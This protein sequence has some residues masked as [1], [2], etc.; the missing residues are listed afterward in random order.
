MDVMGVGPDSFALSLHR[1]ELTCAVSSGLAKVTTQATPGTAVASASN[2]AGSRDVELSVVWSFISQQEQTTTNKQRKDT[3]SK[4]E[5]MHVSVYVSTV[6]IEVA[7]AR[8]FEMFTECIGTRLANL[9]VSFMY[10]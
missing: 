8:D 2:S 5:E 7:W 10:H 3:Q 1:S 4:N 9:F 6:S